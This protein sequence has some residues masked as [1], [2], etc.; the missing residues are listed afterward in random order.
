MDQNQNGE[1]M[2]PTPQVRTTDIVAD[3]TRVLVEH[4]LRLERNIEGMAE[5]LQRKHFELRMAQKAMDEGERRI[6]ELQDEAH[7]LTTMVEQSLGLLVEAKGMLRPFDQEDT[8]KIEWLAK[9]AGARAEW[10]AMHG[11][12]PA[13]TDAQRQTEGMPMPEQPTWDGPTCGPTCDHAPDGGNH[14]AVPSAG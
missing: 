2:T 8:K 5:A 4:G 11:T 9:C 6:G 12:Q 13:Q 10:D 1:G 3:L 7:R 14:P